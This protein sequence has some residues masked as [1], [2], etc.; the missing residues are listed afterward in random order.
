MPRRPHAHKSS[1][2]RDGRKND[3]LVEQRD[4][5]AVVI[6]L[7][8]LRR[9][10]DD[11][12]RAQEQLARARVR[13]RH[14]ADPVRRPLERRRARGRRRRAVEADV[15]LDAC[16]EERGE[17]GVEEGGVDDGAVAWRD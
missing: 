6:V 11:A 16:G 8:L 9:V 1:K 13:R 4:R 3:S 12:H 7:L 10:A 15:A 14:R 17:E 2:T 5:L